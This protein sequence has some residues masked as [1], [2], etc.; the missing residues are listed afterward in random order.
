[1][2]IDDA[3]TDIIKNI[4]ILNVST[5]LKKELFKRM[6]KIVIKI[7]GKRLGNIIASYFGSKSSQK[8]L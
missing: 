4:N 5:H 7:L 2:E 6:K 1:M 8:E 3:F